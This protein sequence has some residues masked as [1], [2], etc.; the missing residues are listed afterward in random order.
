VSF[1]GIAFV[2]AVVLPLEAA[3]RA[4]PHGWRRPELVTDIAFLPL[5]YGVM[6][7][8]FTALNAALRVWIDVPT[9]DWPLAVR[10]V[11]AVVLGDL[12]LYWGHRL[13]H[14][15][16]FLWRF[17]AVHHTA[18]A[19][20]WVAAH[21]EHPVDALWTQLTFNLPFLVFGLDLYVAMPLIVF[22]SVWAVIL[23]ANVTLPLGPLGLLVG[24]P[25]L[26]RAHHARDLPAANFGNLAPYLDV[27]FRTHRR[28]V[29]E[30]YALGVAGVPP[31]S[32]VAHLLR[33][34]AP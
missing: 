3:F 6:A 26:H 7:G 24:D 2:A 18:P 12:G 5:Q 13:A 11:A 28:P 30:S 8:L 9:P 15:V 10:V 21:R 16:P 34:E 32:F 22:R 25:V 31:R 19:L 29:D 33:P 23:H 27:L 14:A 1:F 20:D 17:H 4:R